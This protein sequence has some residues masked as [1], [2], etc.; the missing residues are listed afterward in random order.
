[1]AC[2]HTCSH[3]NRPHISSHLCRGFL[4]SPLCFF[5]VFPFH[6]V[7]NPVLRGKDMYLTARVRRPHSRLMQKHANTTAPNIHTQTDRGNRHPAHIKEV[8]KALW[9]VAGGCLQTT[10]ILPSWLRAARTFLH[11]AKLSAWHLQSAK[12]RN[13]AAH[14]NCSGLFSPSWLMWRQTAWI[15]SVCIMARAAGGGK[16]DIIWCIVTDAWPTLHYQNVLSAL[17]HKHESASE[18][19]HMRA[20]T[21]LL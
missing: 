21:M 12:H 6:A 10:V 18:W 2:R 16:S 8:A 9:L 14:D 5:H 3:T 19:A 15:I 20:H 4:S 7:T 11:S 17:I 13:A 1:M